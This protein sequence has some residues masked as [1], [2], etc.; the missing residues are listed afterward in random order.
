MSAFPL[1]AYHFRV[2]W[3]GSRIDFTEVKGLDIFIEP[4]VFRNG[5]APSDTVNHMPGLE[6]FNTITLK[7]DIV[8][9]DNDMY[10]WIKTKQG[11][12]IERRD[13]TISLL[14][15]EHNPAVV[16]TAHAAFPIR[17]SGPNFMASDSE[18]AFEELELVHEGLSVQHN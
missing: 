8:K 14:D 3:G 12:T 4:I 9:G 7:R 17:Y 1:P 5:A 15:A 13:I 2:E 10:N 18:V 11:N 16:W 6:K